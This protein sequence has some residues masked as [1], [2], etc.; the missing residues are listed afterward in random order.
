MLSKRTVVAIVA[1][2][3]ALPAI[4]A[5]KKRMSNIP[6]EAAK[7]I[8]AAEE[9]FN[10]SFDSCDKEK[11]RAQCG[12]AA[13]QRI[14]KDVEAILAKYN[15]KVAPQQ[16]VT[17]GDCFGDLKPDCGKDGKAERVAAPC[18]H[19]LTSHVTKNGG[20]CWIWVCEIHKPK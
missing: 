11:N 4:A 13:K 19:C 5:E 9:R 2:L 20:A 14:E 12:A 15:V 8:L 16:V 17:S 1:V 10:A 3:L 6:P 7:A 18:I